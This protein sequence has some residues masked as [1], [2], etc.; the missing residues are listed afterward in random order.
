MA[1]SSVNKTETPIV[2]PTTINVR[3]GV[4]TAGRIDVWR[5]DPDDLQMNQKLRGRIEKPDISGLIHSIRQVGQL[6]PI[7]A[8]K[9]TDNG[10]HVV[11]GFSRVEA[12]SALKKEQPD[13]GWTVL[14]RVLSAINDAK[15]FSLGLAENIVRNNLSPLEAARGVERLRNVFNQNVTD[16]ATALGRSA[17]WVYQM[18]KLLELPED[19]LQRIH[20]REVSIEAAFLLAKDPNREKLIEKVI[21][22][23]AVTNKANENK[24]DKLEVGAPTAKPHAK[25]TKGDVA[26]AALK[27]ASGKKVKPT[28]TQIRKTLESIDCEYHIGVATLLDYM[29]GKVTGEDLAASATLVEME[30]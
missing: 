12:I 26:K 4:P 9:D 11:A 16:V 17:P 21:A 24:A 1:T 14:V 5:V 10:L 30:Q 2:D 19:L 25:V 13:K 8:R 7:V 23:K 22:D 29:S 28:I 15:G 20:R 3:V 6:Q 18:E 27:K